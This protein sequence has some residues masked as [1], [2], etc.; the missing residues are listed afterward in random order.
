[1]SK[2][3]GK[4]QRGEGSGTAGSTARLQERRGGGRKV[5]ASRT[6]RRRA[7]ARAGSTPWRRALAGSW[8]DLP[9]L[10][11]RLSLSLP[12]QQPGRFHLRRHRAA[13][14]RPPLAR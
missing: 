14:R 12:P 1:M 3:A 6:R 7:G 8:G 9:L 13:L 10:A 2:V 5:D 4:G 11:R